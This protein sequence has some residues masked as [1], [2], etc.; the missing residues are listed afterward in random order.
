M[1]ECFLDSQN[2]RTEIRVLSNWVLGSRI[3]LRKK[4]REVPDSE[5]VDYLLDWIWNEVPSGVVDG[6]NGTALF[7][8]TQKGDP[9]TSYVK[10]WKSS[11]REMLS[12]E[13]KAREYKND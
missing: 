1:G 5:L 6:D 9:R 13:P 8:T 11:I 3:I 7:A 10:T 4:N 12:K 2:G